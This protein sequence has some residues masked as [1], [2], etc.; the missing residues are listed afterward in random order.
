MLSKY[1]SG[2][3][4]LVS[5]IPVVSTHEH[6]LPDP[7]QKQLTLDL[8][9]ANSYITSIAQSKKCL[10]GIRDYN[11]TARER[12]FSCRIPMDEKDRRMDFLTQIRYNSYFVWL[13][14]AVQT[15][16]GFDDS[17]TPGNWDE[18]S[19]EISKKHKKDGADLEILRGIGNYQ[20]AILDPYWDY[21]SDIGHPE[22]F[23]VAMRTDM[24]ITSF[25]PEIVD[26]D[27]NSPFKQFPDAPTDNFGDYLHYL[28]DL[29]IKWRNHG[30]VA[31]KSA[32][33][34][35]R[36][37]QYDFP[38][39]N[40]AYQTFFKHPSQVTEAEH[41]NYGDF[42]FHWFCELCKELEVPFQIHT[43]L[44]KLQGSNPLFLEPVI[45]K[46]P[47]LR[48]V[49]LHCGYPWCS[50][51][52][53][54]AHNHNNVLL[55]MTWVPI[56]STSAAKKAFSE[57]LDVAHSSDRI[58]WGSDAWTSEEAYGALLAWRQVVSQVLA[59]KVDEGY[60]CLKDAES[61]ASKLLY[62]NAISTYGL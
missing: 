21:G 32:S 50:E 25:H 4:Q 55:D 57:F 61:L 37:L 10:N 44:G 29:F 51:A 45:I 36:S 31:L 8:L 23:S 27:G 17:I 62:Q 39:K 9:F 59:D 49:L 34:Y 52:A 6:H 13:E 18:I 1:Y 47:E 53:G 54:L 2:L 3:Y 20:R 22:L 33:A 5:K 35:D 58:A 26:H 28:K 16:Y 46:Y 19:Q 14:K 12:P 56:I 40:R 60:I 11:P 43:G 15:I 24:F 48:F 7:F 30:G 41:K 42:M 38:D